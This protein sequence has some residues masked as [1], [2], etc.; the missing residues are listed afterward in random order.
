MYE[1]YVCRRSELGWTLLV[2]PGHGWQTCDL[3][4]DMSNV[5]K[6]LTHVAPT[7]GSRRSE[8]GS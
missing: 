7:A 1:A 2:G 8:C 3:A 5:L 6:M 4:Y